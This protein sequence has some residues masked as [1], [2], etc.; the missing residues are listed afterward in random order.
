MS[1]QHAGVIGSSVSLVSF[2]PQHGVQ[3]SAD[4]QC[5]KTGNT[6]TESH[7]EDEEYSLIIQQTNTRKQR[8]YYNF[9]SFFFCDG[10]HDNIVKTLGSGY[11]SVEF[12]TFGSV[13]NVFPEWI[14]PFA[15]NTRCLKLGN[16]IIIKD[17]NVSLIYHKR[18]WSGAQN[19][20]FGFKRYNAQE[21]AIL[22]ILTE[23]KNRPDFHTL[24]LFIITSG[25]KEGSRHSTK[26][27]QESTPP[28]L[29]G[30]LPHPCV[31]LL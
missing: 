3:G 1:L 14:L 28:R 29:W 5:W 26:W 17:A 7:Q 21:L 23:T 19:R 6:D 12:Q 24:L 15:Y 31:L 27:E 4:S 2:S 18:F 25:F 8:L 10:T 22:R 11:L 9:T 13:A 20:K 16:E 30:N